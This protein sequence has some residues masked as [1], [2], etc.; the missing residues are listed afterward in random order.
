MWCLSRGGRAGPGAQSESQLGAGSSHSAGQ[1]QELGD[2]EVA[3]KS[4]FAL[5]LSPQHY[6]SEKGGRSPWWFLLS[7]R[8]PE[9]DVALRAELASG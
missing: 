4:A 5:L 1:A 3:R 7:L 9:T 6:S 8:C 2:R